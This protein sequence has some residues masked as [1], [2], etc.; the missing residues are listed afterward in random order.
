MKLP[1]KFCPPRKK[2]ELRNFTL[3]CRILSDG[4]F[5]D[6]EDRSRDEEVAA[7]PCNVKLFNRG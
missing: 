5:W 6:M 1:V 3:I 2:F 4:K 7:I